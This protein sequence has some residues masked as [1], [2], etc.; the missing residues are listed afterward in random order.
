MNTELALA[1]GAGAGLGLT[2]LV[3]H[4]AARQTARSFRRGQALAAE[5][6]LAPAAGQKRGW[7]FWPAPRAR[8]ALQG[9]PAELV[10]FTTG[11]GASR[12][13]WCAL[14]LRPESTGG[15][16]FQLVRRGLGTRLSQL[17]GASEAVLGEPTFDAAWMVRTNQP[18]FLQRALTPDVC[19]RVMAAV[20]DGT[21]PVRS[22]WFS[23]DGTRIVYV[24]R[25][26]FS[27][28]PRCERLRRVAVMLGE[29][30]AIAEEHD[31]SLDNDE[32]E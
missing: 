16:T 19:H 8:G 25:G 28:V 17:L 21:R 32:T 6:G 3:L 31:R 5:L 1:V 11:S 22:A 15:L 26:D 13:S 7:V 27:A 14:S 4:L 20:A 2:A 9:R 12:T 30:A 29:L 10:G 23:L 24:E 18:A